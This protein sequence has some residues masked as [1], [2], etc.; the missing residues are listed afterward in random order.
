MSTKVMKNK[1]QEFVNMAPWHALPSLY[2]MFSSVI[3]SHAAHSCLNSLCNST[4][5]ATGGGLGTLA[6]L[7]EKGGRREK[8]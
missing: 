1:H 7:K 3:N 8:K 5:G 2:Y 4:F 6:T